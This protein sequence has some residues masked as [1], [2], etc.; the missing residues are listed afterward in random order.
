M[1]AVTY[2]REVCYEL[3]L[4]LENIWDHYNIEG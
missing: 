1:Y 4:I 3:T 2:F